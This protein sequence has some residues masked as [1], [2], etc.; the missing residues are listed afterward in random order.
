M[1]ERTLTRQIVVRVEQDLYEAL[2]RDAKKHG[3]TVAQTIRFHLGRHLTF[4]GA[5]AEQLR[6]LRQTAGGTSTVKEG[7]NDVLR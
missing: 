4:S 6:A 2:E 3:R 1:R 5:T 7:P